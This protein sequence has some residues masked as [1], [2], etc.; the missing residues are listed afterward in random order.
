[1]YTNRKDN[2]VL[3]FLLVIFFMTMA[4]FSMKI[5]IGMI[6]LFEEFPV[7]N[8]L[9]RGAQLFY[10]S[11]LL[12][13]LFYHRFDESILGFGVSQFLFL[14]LVL[15]CLV[16]VSAE[17]WASNLV[18]GTLSLGLAIFTYFVGFNM[19]FRVS[20]ESKLLEYLTIIATIG[21]CAEYL[22]V[23]ST[24]RIDFNHTALTL[25]ISYIP[26]IFTPLLLLNHNKL[27][28]AIF[29]LVGYV[30]IDSGKRGGI[31]ALVLALLFYYFT[32]KKSI[33]SAK[34][35]RVMIIAIIAIVLLW[36]MLSEF[37]ENTEFFNRLLHGSE[38]SDYSSGRLDIYSDTLSKYFDSD[39]EGMFLGHGLGSVAKVSKFGATA[40]NDFIEA[41]Y[42]FGIVG[43]FS[44]IFFYFSF[45]KQTFSISKQNR[46]MKGVFVYTLSLTFFLSTISQ[47]IVYQY[48]CL[49]SFTW[50][51][52]S[53]ARQQEQLQYNN[54]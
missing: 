37:V 14:F 9:N 31:I 30:L 12:I 2:N 10:F 18:Y 52:I 53:G 3:S 36:G 15:N 32:I 28:P 41:L 40:H 27:S 23:S 19:Y 47:I 8:F 39:I 1:M 38:D 6:S 13:V 24:M 34:I 46:K 16:G 43:L 42:D 51:A 49:F 45:I 21:L 48:L 35:I 5:M 50:G 20:R 4:A 11:I 7:S 17:N 29:L 22:I 54:N 25:G 26:L 33:E 44:Y